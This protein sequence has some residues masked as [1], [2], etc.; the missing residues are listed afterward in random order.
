MAAAA[1]LDDGRRI[2]AFSGDTSWTDVLLEVGRDADLFIMECYAPDGPCATHT[3]WETL[4]A[5]LPEITAGRVMLTHMNPDML[6]RCGQ[7]SLGT[8]HDGMVIDV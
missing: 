3:D 1:S 2:L 6:D 4:H 5:H 7:L 8:L